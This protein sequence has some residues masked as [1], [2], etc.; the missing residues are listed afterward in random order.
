MARFAVVLVLLYPCLPAAA[1]DPA[2]PPADPPGLAGFW[3]PESVVY[4]G[5]EQFSDPNAR[6]SITLVVKDGEYRMYF[7]KDR[8]KDLHVRLVTAELKADPAAKTVELTIK[9][10]DKKGLRCHGVYEVSGG[11]LRLCYGPAE[12]PRPTGFDAPAGS[13]YF[14]EVWATEK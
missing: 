8:A 11:K 13:G 5:A 2:K 14:C 3:K 10:G 6:Q 12:K 1:A 7:C 9:D 4:D